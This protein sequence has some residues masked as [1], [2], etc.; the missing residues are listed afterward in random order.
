MVL[1]GEENETKTKVHLTVMPNTRWESEIDP[2]SNHF[3]SY[4]IKSILGGILFADI[5]PKIGNGG[6]G[7][8]ATEIIH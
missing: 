5:S 2:I 6:R 7:N 1:N 3:I 4:Y 8:T